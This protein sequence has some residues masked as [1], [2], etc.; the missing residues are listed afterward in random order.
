MTNDLEKEAAYV[1]SL[2]K[3]TV[4]KIAELLGKGQKEIAYLIERVSKIG[5]IRARRQAFI[6]Q[7]PPTPD[8]VIPKGAFDPIPPNAPIVL[9][10]RKEDA[11]ILIEVPGFTHEQTKAGLAFELF[12]EWRVA[13]GNYA[14]KVQERNSRAANLRTQLQQLQATR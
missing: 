1:E 10:Q 2:K 8:T 11:V 14:A 13:A 7:L 9:R 12:N 4:A 3:E 6:N 5:D